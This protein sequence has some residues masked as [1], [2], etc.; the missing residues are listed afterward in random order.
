MKKNLKLISI[1]TLIVCAFSVSMIFAASP[2]GG[3]SVDSGKSVLPNGLTLVFSDISNSESARAEVT[4]AQAATPAHGTLVSILEIHPVDE[5]N[6]VVSNPGVPVTVCVNISGLVPSDGVQ[7]LHIKS[8]GG[9]EIINGVC[10][11][12]YV[13]FQVDSFSTFAFF[14]TKNTTTATTTATSPKTGI[15]E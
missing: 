14:V 2:Q 7:I 4:A 1:L 12:G 11:N 3:I 9:S 8:T 5:N 10:G 15:Y 13:T 6:K